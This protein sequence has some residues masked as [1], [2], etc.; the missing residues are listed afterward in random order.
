MSN[1]D[2]PYYIINNQKQL[3]NALQHIFGLNLRLPYCVE[4]IH[5][6]HCYFNLYCTQYNY[7][8]L[9]GSFSIYKPM[10]DE[11][12][13]LEVDN[14]KLTLYPDFEQNIIY[15]LSVTLDDSFNFVSWKMRVYHVVD[16]VDNLLFFSTENN[17][18]LASALFNHNKDSVYRGEWEYQLT[19]NTAIQYFLGRFE[20]FITLFCDHL[21]IFKTYSFKEI[22][23]A[24]DND[25][26]E[27]LNDMKTVAEMSFV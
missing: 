26:D 3:L 16:D 20:P 24:L 25:N 17:F 23:D 18:I 22:L 19:K 4:Q 27:T 21:N 1:C 2:D 9:I 8:K 12:W 14:D 7:Q 11:H 5:P 6:E 15:R 10:N 13:L